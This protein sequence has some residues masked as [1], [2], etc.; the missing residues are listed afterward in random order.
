MNKKNFITVFSVAALFFACNETPKTKEVTEHEKQ[1]QD[2]LSKLEQ[3]R[4][5]DSL[6]Q[7]NPLLI[8]PPDS[9]YT[10]DYVDKYETGIV[11][12]KGFFRFGKR[13]GQWMS[14]YPSGLAWSE[15]HYD[16]GLREGPNIAYYNGGGKRYEGFYKNDMRD[17]TWCY[18]DSIGKMIEKVEFKNNKIV[19]NLPLK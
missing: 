14:F 2:S 17:S 8:I 13:H 18:Y 19:K 6:K 16:K 11:K 5:G 4:R 3:K 1:V 15:M 9:N 12:F 7:K 10:G